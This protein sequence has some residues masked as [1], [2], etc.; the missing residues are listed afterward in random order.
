[1]SKLLEALRAS[2]KEYPKVE[3]PA[4]PARSKSDH[5][6]TQ[7]QLAEIYFSSGASERA[8]P[9][10]LPAPTVIK[11]IERPAPSNLIPWIIASV[12][13]LITAFSLFSTKRIFV[14]VRVIDEDHPMAVSRYEERTAREDEPAPPVGQMVPIRN[15]VFEGA[16]KLKSSSTREGLSLV[17]SSVSPFAQ[18]S[19][20]FDPP[21]DLTGAKVVFYARGT[22]GGER[23]GFAMKDRDNVLAFAKGKIFPFPDG[24]T[25]EWQRAEV[26]LSAV[27]REFNAKHVVSFR[28]EF[29]TNVQNRAGDAILVKD[30][31]IL[32]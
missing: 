7:E 10:E 17:N 18:A 25:T 8:R 32:S 15:A 26:P 21:R 31:Q 1:M 27:L 9:A 3:G 2:T 20:R 14:D 19:V 11:V 28:F 5:E 4:S 13:F 6:A 16:A 23:L 24:L 22:R 12:A 30:L 29:G